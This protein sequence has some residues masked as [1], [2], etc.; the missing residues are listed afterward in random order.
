MNTSKIPKDIRE[1]SRLKAVN[2]FRLSKNPI[3]RE[4]EPGQIWSTHSSFQLPNGEQ[5]QTDEPKLVIILLGSGELSRKYESITVAPLSNHISMAS[6]YDFVNRERDENK[7]SI[8]FD[9]MVEVWNETP[10]LRGQ[11]KN[12]I[13]S[14]SDETMKALH[15]LYSSRLLN[16]DIPEILKKYIGMPI[17]AEDDPR[18]SFQ[19]EEISAVSYLAKAATGSLELEIVEE[20]TPVEIPNW[21]TLNIVPILGKLSN[22]LK[23]PSSVAASAAN[24]VDT[25]TERCLIVQLEKNEK[26]IFE[27]LNSRMRPYSIYLKAYSIAPEFIGRNCIVSVITKEQKYKSDITS[28]NEGIRIEVGNDSHFRID[29][30]ESVELAIELK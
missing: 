26:L 9:F 18:L 3:P 24:N 1:L 7:F 6:E 2:F 17:V 12:F 13:G 14:L 27:L 28:L 5:Y 4:L 11:L 25:E 23:N 22:F 16:S 19:E 20:E 8:P 21:L 29:N 10:A 15:Q 30:V